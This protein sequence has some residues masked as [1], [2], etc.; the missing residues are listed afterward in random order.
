M[1][2][3]I[4]SVLLFSLLGGEG[5]ETAAV[6]EYRA[7]RF[8]QASLLL[9]TMKDRKRAKRE[10]W[11][12]FHQQRLRVGF[13]AS[14]VALELRRSDQAIQWLKPL[15]RR[16]SRTSEIRGEIAET[17]AKAYMRNRQAKDAI[18]IY[19]WMLKNLG[20]RWRR[21]LQRR[22]LVAYR[23]AGQWNKLLQLLKRVKPYAKH[24]GGRKWL[25]WQTIYAMDKAG[26][27]KKAAKA[28]RRFLLYY[29]TGSL[30]R[31]V[32]TRL[33]QW[34]QKKL[35]HVNPK[36]W[37]ERQFELTRLVF[38][39]PK[40]ALKEGVVWWKSLRKKL[41]RDRH[42]RN[43]Y[44]LMQARALRKLGKKHEAIPFLEK[45]LKDRK[46]PK[47]ARRLAVR[48]VGK[49]YRDLGLYKQGEKVLHRYAERH[50]EDYR[51]AS[52]AAYQSAWMAMYQAKY[53]K[54]FRLFGEYLRVFPDAAKRRLWRV[55]FFQAWCQ[56]RLGRYNNAIARWKRLKYRS[57]RSSFRRRC[58]YWIARAY[59]RRGDWRKARKGFAK[60]AMSWALSYYG[61]Q[62]QYRLYRLE[63]M[64]P[65]QGEASSCMLEEK[66][67]KKLSRRQRWKMRLQKKWRPPTY[68]PRKKHA[69]TVNGT[70][71]SKLAEQSVILKEKHATLTPSIEG[72][73]RKEADELK[74]PAMFPKLP[75]RCLQ[76]KWRTCKALRRAKL[77]AEMG[78]DK[79]AAVELAKG[80][81]AFRSLREKL[82]AIRWLRSVGAFHESVLVSY[83]LPGPMPHKGLSLD[84]WMKILYP[85]AFSNMMLKNSKKVGVTPAFAWSIMREESLYRPM[86]TSHVGAKGLMQVIDSTGRKISK[87]IKYKGFKPMQLYTPK[88]GI[89]MGTWYLSQLVRKFGGNIFLAA[90][91]YNA[92]PYRIA[93][94]L[95]GRR[96]LDFD[97]FVEE[98]Y[99]TETRIYVK[100]IFRTYAA[101]SFLYFRRLPSAPPT[102]AVRVHNNIDF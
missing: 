69:F 12:S 58:E 34:Q 15:F 6:R 1:Q 2:L 29:P 77:F 68:N 5:V 17:L 20:W 23:K 9:A 70:F 8:E 85:P 24:Y 32:R 59:E 18:K 21:P 37:H 31:R 13:L 55:H 25:W 99:F 76:A 79:D 82:T 42:V 19:H 86:A 71:W 35:C 62:A 51:T 53:K 98:L 43:G 97:E 33:K 49:L 88:V 38:T 56:F 100:R 54:A 81:R 46:A 95:K 44:L 28:M 92:G 10:R 73:I 52:W 64:L 74:Q 7:K 90:A 66:P 50:P 67:K 65:K 57:R 41:Q 78:L 84:S 101:Y 16:H 102:V 93:V 30:S 40:R 27:I 96:H 80:R 60:L 48:I 22:L 45:V 39:Y 83:L 72:T 91:G 14:R 47:Y 36:A 94:W 4:L 11:S 87:E 89:R 75:R 26:K 61:L 3:G 63:V